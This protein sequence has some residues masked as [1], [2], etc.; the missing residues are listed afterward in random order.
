[1]SCHMKPNSELQITAM[2]VALGHDLNQP[3]WLCQTHKWESD[4]WYKHVTNSCVCFLT[5]INVFA[6]G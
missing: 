3:V 5:V 6:V 1:M 4:I 2:L